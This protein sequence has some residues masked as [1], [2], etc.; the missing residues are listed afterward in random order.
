MHRGHRPEAMPATMM[1]PPRH[2][3]GCVRC[4]G[5]ERDTMSGP[6]VEDIRLWRLQA[7]EPRML[8]STIEE[9][10]ARLGVLSA[11]RSYDAIA[12][13]AEAPSKVAYGSPRDADIQ[14]A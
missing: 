7:E 13:N 6:T 11:A 12:A 8:A 2:R 1:T 3:G 10:S 5:M 14:P 4:K 9:A